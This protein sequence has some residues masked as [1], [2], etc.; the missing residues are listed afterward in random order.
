MDKLTLAS[1][2]GLA[3]K[4]ATPASDSMTPHTQHGNQKDNERGSPTSG[5]NKTLVAATREN[6]FARSLSTRKTLSLKQSEVQPAVES[7]VHLLWQQ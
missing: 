3:G 5:A 2:K 1:E 4:G 6:P 7:T